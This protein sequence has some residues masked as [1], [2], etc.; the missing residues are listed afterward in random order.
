MAIDKENMMPNITLAKYLKRLLLFIVLLLIH[1]I[2]VFL[3]IS[4]FFLLYILFFKPKWL[5]A[6]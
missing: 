1:Y 5:D 4:E 3:P 2:F 6:F